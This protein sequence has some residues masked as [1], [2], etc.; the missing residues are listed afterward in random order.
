MVLGE[1]MKVSNHES[2]ERYNMD[3]HLWLVDY[4]FFI[5]SNVTLNVNPNEVSNTKY[6]TQQE[7]R[8][9]MDDKGTFSLALLT[10][11]DM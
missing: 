7:L 2:Y 11:H 8:A 3:I 4:I 9:M 6:V 5:K 1:N 10:R